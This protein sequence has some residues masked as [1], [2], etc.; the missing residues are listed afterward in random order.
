LT[1]GP[2]LDLTGVS[3]TYPG[4]VPVEALKSVTFAVE[5][6]EMVAIVGPSGSGKS[7]LLGLLGCLD[8]PTAGRLLVAGRD[9]G[10]M[11]DGERSRLRREF[12][13]FVFQQFHLVPYLSARQ[14]VETAL[15]Y[16]GL[17]RAERGTRAMDALERVGLTA[18]AHHRPSFLSGGEQ[19]RVA[20]ARAIVSQPQVVLADEPTGNLD[21]QNASMVLDI[22][23][24]VSRNGT[25]VILVTHDMD[26]AGRAGR[27]ITMLDGSITSDVR[28]AA[29]A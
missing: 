27:R 22:L 24:S 3:R 11:R 25:A 26:I 14:N 18:R 20:I 13:G 9:A 28:L 21:S 10:R 6:G 23:E 8:V 1:A 17:S 15:L 4:A 2:V 7:T 12:M 19:Q 16:R 5:P 29:T